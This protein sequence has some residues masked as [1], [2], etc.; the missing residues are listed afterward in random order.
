[1]MELFTIIFLIFLGLYLAVSLVLN[2]LQKKSIQEIQELYNLELPKIV[3][4]INKK[5]PKIT[6]LQFPEGLKPYAQTITDYLESKTNSCSQLVESP[7]PSVRVYV[8]VIE[9]TVQNSVPLNPGGLST[10]LNVV[11]LFASTIPPCSISS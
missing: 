1:M 6:L 3:S 7:Q 9:P 10:K 5:K 2:H 11:G 4:T 8:L